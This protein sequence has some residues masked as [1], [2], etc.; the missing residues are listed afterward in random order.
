[1]IPD[2]TITATRSVSWV[3]V[4]RDD[5]S[6]VFVVDINAPKRPAVQCDGNVVTLTPSDDTPSGHADD[7]V[8][9]AFPDLPDHCFVDAV[10]SRYTAVV[11][12]WTVPEHGW[13]EVSPS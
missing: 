9:I 11:T 13:V 2:P 10:A 12:V 1:V 4:H 7:K 8:T 3:A 5:T 6:A